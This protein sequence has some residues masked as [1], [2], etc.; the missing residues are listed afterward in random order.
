M[1]FQAGRHF[2]CPR[3]QRYCEFAKHSDSVEQLRVIG[4]S[5]SG[6][7]VEKAEL[8]LRL[9]LGSECPK[10]STGERVGRI[11]IG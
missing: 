2:P 1:W 11:Q 4:P 5:R 3:K 7:D 6:D 9:D 10:R 8:H